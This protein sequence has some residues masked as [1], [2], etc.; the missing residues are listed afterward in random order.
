MLAIPASIVWSEKVLYGTESRK[1]IEW[2]MHLAA[3]AKMDIADLLDVIGH[4][5]TI[6]SV[7]AREYGREIAAAYHVI[8][9]RVLV[10]SSNEF[11]DETLLFVMGHECAHAMFKQGGF[12]KDDPGLWSYQHLVHE[13]AADVL[14]AHLAGR[15]SSRRGRNGEALTFN[16]LEETRIV[17]RN[18][19]V[20]PFRIKDRVATEWDGNVRTYVGNGYYLDPNLGSEPLIN[21]V[22]RICRQHD[23]LWEA[24][25][26]IANELHNVD[27]KTAQKLAPGISPPKAVKER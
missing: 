14:G 24:A 4:G 6:S 15:V 3:R 9:R 11:A 21:E 13:V 5:V 8:E 16:L 22:D 19:A 1:P 10:E 2:D 12:L 17:S 7:E 25:R 26:K 23:D 20:G 18:Y 27:L